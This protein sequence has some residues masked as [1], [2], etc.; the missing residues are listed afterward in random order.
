[1]RGRLGSVE[2]KKSAK[3]R[4]SERKKALEVAIESGNFGDA[5]SVSDVAEYLGISDRTARDR[6]KEHGG[7]TIEDGIVRKKNCGED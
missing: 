2:R 7:Y 4:K 1:M 6:I 3:D 5:P